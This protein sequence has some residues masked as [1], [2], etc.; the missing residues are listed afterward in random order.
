MS[1]FIVT[2]NGTKKDIRF[3]DGNEI[4]INDVKHSYEL[5]KLSS[6]SYVLKLD[7]TF[8]DIP[9]GIRNNGKSL[10]TVG[11]ENF[12]VVVRSYL[13][14]KAAG[15]IEQ[16]NKSAHGMEV[17]APMPGMIVK[18]KITEGSVVEQ[19]AAIL[20]LEAMKMENEVRSPSGGILKKI[21]VKE[22]ET[23]EKGTILFLI[24]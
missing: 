7:N 2:V 12:E 4:F 6:D 8:Y 22:G 15:I 3:F 16:K 5:I 21:F 19:G 20:I 18:I 24:E 10:V 14:E 17:K 13:Q 11:G 23:V 1:E 9:S